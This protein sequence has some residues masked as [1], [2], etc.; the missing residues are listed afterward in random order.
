[1]IAKLYSEDLPLMNW[2]CLRKHENIFEFSII[3]WYRNVFMPQRLPPL[4]CIEPSSLNTLRPRQDGRHFADDIFTCIF[5]NENGCILIK[6]SLKYVRKGSIDNNPALVQIMAW[7]R[8]GDKPLSE[9]M[10]VRSLTHTYVTRPQWVKIFQ[11]Q[12]QQEYMPFYSLAPGKFEWNFRYLILQI[13]SVI[14]GWGISCELALRWMSLSLTDDKST[15]VQ[16]MA[17]CCEATSHYLSQCWPRS[18]SSYG[19]TKPKWVKQ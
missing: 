12:Y 18:L 15:L 17:W 1:M 7:R 11:L 10:M 14:D 16:V 5:F 9:P 4:P 6:F 3:S 19:V 8:P 2:I 13:I